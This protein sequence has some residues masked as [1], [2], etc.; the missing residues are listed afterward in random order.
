MQSSAS[1]N[2]LPF[3]NL[4]GSKKL[5]KEGQRKVKSHV[6]QRIWHN[7]RASG[8]MRRDG[9]GLETNDNAAASEI[10]FVS[11]NSSSCQP[12]SNDT[13]SASSSRY[14]DEVSAADTS[15]L[16][17]RPRTVVRPVSGWPISFIT[18]VGYGYDPFDSVPILLT[19]RIQELIFY[20]ESICN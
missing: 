16:D 15:R 3:L 2:E 8:R 1:Q 11:S 5:D 6:M 14:L 10:A 19:P 7:H 4:L 13:G 12:W 20:C 17:Y 9:H 18:R